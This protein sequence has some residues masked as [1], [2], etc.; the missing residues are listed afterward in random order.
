MIFPDWVGADR[1]VVTDGVELYTYRPGLDGPSSWVS[2]TGGCVTDFDCPPG[3]GAYATISQPV[4]SQDGRRLAYTYQ[5]L[6]G[7]P[8]RRIASLTAPPP[9]QVTDTCLLPGQ[10]TSLN[11][12]TFSPDGATIAY[13][14]SH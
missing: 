4:V 12:L 14:D 7:L 13:D 10:E 5:P 3:Q 9:A 11:P 6:F 1:L 8:G 2:F